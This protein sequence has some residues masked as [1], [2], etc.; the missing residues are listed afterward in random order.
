MNRNQKKLLVGAVVISVLS[1]FTATASAQEAGAYVGASVGQSKVDIDTAG[2]SSGFAAAGLSA[3]GI[4]VDENDTGW[5][6]FGGYKF[7]KYFALEGGYVDLG[8]F[9]AAT[10]ITAVRGAAI[11]PTAVNAT[12]KAEEGYFLTAVG[13]LPLSNNF[14]IFGKLG[15]YSMKTKL[16]VAVAGTSL[17]NSER[18]EDMLYGVGLGYDFT[19]NVSLRAEW[20]R[21]EKV[22]DENKTGQGDV[23]LISVGLVFKF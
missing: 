16:D 12:F 19:R 13:I 20:E 18:N 2:L 5:K 21:F 9:S 7:N 4:S 6:L 23:D 17:S 22:G 8:Q 15:A 14:S 1:A 10:T 3:T 11:T